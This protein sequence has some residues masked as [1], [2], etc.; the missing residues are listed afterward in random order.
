MS[1]ISGRFLYQF[2]I[3]AAVAVMVSL[4]V[5][6]VLTPTLSAR[7]LGGEAARRRSVSPRSGSRAASYA[8][9]TSATPR[10]SLVMRHRYLTA[11]ASVLVMARWSAVHDGQAGLPPA[12]RDE[13]SSAS[14]RSAAEHQLHLDGPGHAVHRGRPLGLPEIRTILSTR[15][16]GFLGTVNTGDIYVRIAPHE[17]RYGRSIGSSRAEASRPIRRVPWQL[18]A[19]R[20]DDQGPRKLRPYARRGVIVGVR[21]YPSFNIGGGSFD[22]DFSITGRTSRS[23][24]STHELV[25]RASDRGIDNLDRTLKLDK[26]EL[27]VAIDRER[28]ADLGVSSIDI[29]TALRLMVGGDQEISRFRDDQTNEELRRA[30]A[31]RERYRRDPHRS[32]SSCCREQGS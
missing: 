6:F 20:R 3:T 21:N 18:H 1:S 25:K 29:G 15:G 30:P 11:L 5:S 16:G 32:R 27:R 7:M 17:E 14:P 8:G 13:A 2:G 28:A 10:C 12:G 9:S 24:R 4:L 19:D 22:I 23:S 26:P 31:P